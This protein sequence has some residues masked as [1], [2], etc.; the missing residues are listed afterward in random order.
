MRHLVSAITPYQIS[1]NKYRVLY[2][3]LLIT[4]EFPNN[5]C[6]KKDMFYVRT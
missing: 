3:K 6:S 1:K 4:T 5:L 2:R